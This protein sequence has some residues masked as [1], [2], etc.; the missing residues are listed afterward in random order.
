MGVGFQVFQSGG[1]HY[2][3]NDNNTL[4]LANW[5]AVG[6]PANAY[7]D[8]QWQNKTTVASECALWMCVQSFDT[9]QTN[10]NQTQTVTKSFSQINP[11]TRQAGL[12]Y[13]VS[14]LG[15][16]GDM[17]QALDD[18]TVYGGALLALTEYFA[19]LFNGSIS[20]NQAEQI[21]SSD[22]VQAIWEASADLDA[23]LQT[24]AASMTNVIR[25]VGQAEPNTKY[26]GT[27]FQLGY[28]VRWAWIVLPAILVGM[29]LLILVVIM[30]KTTRSPVQ[31]WK[32]S[33]LALLF[34]NVDHGLRE[35]AMGQL[36]EYHGVDK[37]VGKSQVVLT[38]EM[39]RSW[40]F[41]QA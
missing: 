32:G 15:L 23:W 18:F 31:A 36:E 35:G 1:F 16:P 28:D 14:F 29:S 27:G 26:N 4:Y 11:R 22:P 39:D 8:T 24:V 40:G 5:E 41:K 13:N 7:S 2:L 21:F 10:S 19:T 17:N 38:R 20:L 37:L 3:R 30:V 9:R 12:V 34:M 25:T 33:P 6:A